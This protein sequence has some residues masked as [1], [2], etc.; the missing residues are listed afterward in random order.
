MST[1]TVAKLIRKLT[2]F[3][4]EAEVIVEDW[5]GVMKV[6]ENVEGYMCIDGE[7]PIDTVAIQFGE[8]DA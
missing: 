2:K 7:G 1:M 6:V 5:K 8:S 4:M 3:P